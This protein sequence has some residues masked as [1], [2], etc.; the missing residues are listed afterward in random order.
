MNKS[1]PNYARYEIDNAGNV[2]NCQSGLKLS[3]DDLKRIK[4]IGDDGIRRWVYPLELIEELF[5][6][7]AIKED[8]YSK[9]VDHKKLGVP[10]KSETKGLYSV[11]Q[12]KEMAP[13]ERKGLH[14]SKKLSPEDVLQIRRDY[15]AGVKTK[16]I[17]ADDYG[18]AWQTAG[19]I[20][21]RKIYG[22]IAEEKRDDNPFYGKG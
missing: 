18:I 19:K 10:E 22:S 12:V 14:V 17:I 11:A 15:D 1:I 4:L 3:P 16:K 2:F 5:K 9:E 7:E 20:C 6:P 21:N 8:P 13:T